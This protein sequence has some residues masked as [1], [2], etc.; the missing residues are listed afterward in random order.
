MVWERSFV[1]MSVLGGASVEEALDALSQ[2][3]EARLGELLAKLRDTRRA[4][5]AQALAAAAQE[6]VVAANEVTW[7]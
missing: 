7:R 3:A 2:G 1:A 6:I 5:R 4:A